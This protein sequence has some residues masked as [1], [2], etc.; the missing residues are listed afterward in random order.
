MNS[1][2]DINQKVSIQPIITENF[3]LKKQ[4][5]DKD[6]YTATVERLSLM[7]DEF[8]NYYISFSGGKDS[9]VLLQ[10]LLKVAEEKDKLPINVLF[11]DL[12]AQYK[13]TIRH[14][15]EMLLNNPK[16]KPY[17]ICLPFNLRNSVSIYEPQ[18][19]CWNEKK[20]DVWVRDMPVYDC[21]INKDN[22]PAEWNNWF[23]E[24]MEF[25]EFINK[26]G[27]F[28]RG[29][30]KE[31]ELTANIVGIRTDESLNRFLAI[32]KRNE[33]TKFKS[34]S[35]TTRLHKNLYS[36]YPIYDWKTQDIWT[37]VG[38]Y[39][40]KYNKI[41]DLIYMTGRSIHEAR[42]CQPYGDDQRKGLDLFRK[43]EPDTWGK[44]VE[45]VAGANFGNIYRGL[46]I[47]GNG[48]IEKP[49]HFTWKEYAEF[50]LKTIPKY[51]AH[52]Y[53]E[54]IEQFLN[55]WEIEEGWKKE[56]VPDASFPK[57]DK[58]WIKK[59]GT[60]HRKIPSWERIARCIL[61]NDIVCKSLSFGCIVGGY[62][63]YLKLKEQ[64][65]E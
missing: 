12:E 14:V 41:Y 29:E 27:L 33:D 17:W 54:R 11:I 19:I 53:K 36:I 59:D 4:Y 50:L 63:R 48:K 52:I 23:Y 35:W 1:D 9:S 51:Q 6:V 20:K 22:M 49:D 3:S 26:F 15:E 10:M 56:D 44:V 18:W 8:S 40:F 62:P 28:I 55:W 47:L 34:L 13:A 43:I 60:R 57:S 39:N 5:L 32:K 37:A 24:G 7:F 61:K 42:I 65:G 46:K 21:V 38:K 45:R 30:V 25:E 31:S 64:Y 16:I 2:R 58:R